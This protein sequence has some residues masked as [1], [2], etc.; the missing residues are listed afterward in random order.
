MML[1]RAFRS[2]LL[3]V[4][5]LCL[6]SGTAALGQNVADQ[7]MAQRASD[8][9]KAARNLDVPKSQEVTALILQERFEEFERRSKLYEAGFAQ[10]PAY[11]SPLI[12]LYDALERRNDKVLEKL[13]KWVASRPSYISYGAR[14]VWKEKRGYWLRGGESIERVPNDAFASMRR[15]HDEARGDLLVALEMNAKFVPAY[16]SLI[17]IERASGRRKSAK[18]MLAN[19]VRAVPLTYYVRFEY[20][21][22]LTPRWGGSYERMQTYTNDL[23]K[24]AM[25]NPRIWNL[26]GEAFAERGDSARNAGDYDS[27]IRHY[28]TALSYGDRMAFLKDRGYVYMKLK[29]HDL[30]LADLTHYREYDQSNAEVN[31]YISQLTSAGVRATR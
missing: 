2:A 21:Q 15:V 22:S 18:A 20:L 26:K 23:D 6:L 7:T 8:S 14:G 16:N 11:E 10:D 29:Q 1:R 24:K 13:D 17:R 28:T 19:A 4:I 12:K 31:H 3:P 27:A 9:L 30:A 25:A 5:S